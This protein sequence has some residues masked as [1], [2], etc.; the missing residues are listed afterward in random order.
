[1]S[2]DDLELDDDPE[3]EDEGRRRPYFKVGMDHEG[4][5]YAI[6]YLRKK[7][8]AQKKEFDQL[9]LKEPDGKQMEMLDRGKG[10]Q[11]GY[12][13]MLS[14]VAAVPYST[15]IS[16]KARDYLKIGEAMTRMGFTIGE[17]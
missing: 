8:M 15:I 2:Q 12:N 16:I 6:V 3:A 4:D 17:E 10:R 14:S 5:L 7:Y 11:Q 1:M 9:R 13:H